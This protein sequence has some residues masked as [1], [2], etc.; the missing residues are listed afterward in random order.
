MKELKEVIHD[1]HEK[2]DCAEMYAKEAVKHKEQYP[3][4]AAVYYRIATDDLAHMDMLHKQAVDMVDEKK[5][6]GREVPM[7]MQAVWDWEHEKMMD[8][9]ADVKR[10]LDMYKA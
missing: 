4:L 9:T 8:E 5:R 10:L 1:I 6:N 3:A 2:L 7:A